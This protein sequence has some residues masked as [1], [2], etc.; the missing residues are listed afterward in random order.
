[1]NN[2]LQKQLLAIQGNLLNYAY[3]LTSDR[4][5]AYDLLQDTTLK[6]LDSESKYTP[7]TN[8]TGWVFTI[9]RNLFINSYRR[10]TRSVVDVD[11]SDDLYMLDAPSVTDRDT[12]DESYAV[13]EIMKVIDSYPPEFRVPFKLYVAGYHYNEI[14]E[15]M[16]LPLGT[17]KSRIFFARRRLR[18]DLK[19]YKEDI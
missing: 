2:K 9:M 13:V 16:H 15:K 10:M 17:V 1:M 5:R 12:P 11:R 7:G 18:N 19:D 6:A 3:S 4:D 14:A 8:F